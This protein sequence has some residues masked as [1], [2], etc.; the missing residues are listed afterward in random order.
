LTLLLDAYAAQPGLQG[1]AVAIGEALLA[2][3]RPGE[4]LAWLEAHPPP[5][6]MRARWLA[7]LGL[8]QV[9][10]GLGPAAEATAQ[11]LREVAPTSAQA[12]RIEAELALAMKSW[13]QALGRFGALKLMHPDDGP[14]RAGE[15][16]ALLGLNRPEDAVAAFDTCAEIAPGCAACKLG[17]GIALREA[18]R[19]EQA[20]VAFADAAALDALDPRIPF[21]TARTL[22]ALLRRDEAAIYTERA[23]TLALQ[24][25]RRLPLR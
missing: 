4:A 12:T 25:G 5:P 10:R 24:L 13:P 20:L 8:A 17:L 2:M 19:A 1:N 3:H 15:G 23:D 7:A 18:D 16:W 6:S 22:R 11:S 21:E 14:A 9:R